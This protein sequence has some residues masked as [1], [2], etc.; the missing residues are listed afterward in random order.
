MCARVCVGGGGISRKEME[1]PRFGYKQLEITGREEREK[2]D[3]NRLL[4][5]GMRRGGERTLE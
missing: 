2:L 5:R 3:R 4:R 1:T